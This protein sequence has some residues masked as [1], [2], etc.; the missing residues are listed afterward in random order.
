MH[1]FDWGDGQSVH[2]DEWHVGGIIDGL[3]YPTGLSDLFNA[4]SGWNPAVANGLGSPPID[5][6][7]VHNPDGFAYGSL[8]LYLVKIFT[9]LLAWFSQLSLLGHSVPGFA[10]WRAPD[11]ILAGRVLSGVFDTITVFLVF[12][13]AKR[14]ADEPAGL[15]AAALA[16]F[17]V[18][19]QQ[20]AHFTTVDS[21]L[22]TFTTGTILASVTLY[23]QGRTRD[24]AVLGLWLAAA[25]ATKASAVTLLALVVLAFL[26]RQIEVRR[27]I[28]W[29]TLGRA[30]LLGG[31][32]L[33]AFFLFQPYTFVDW[34]SFKSGLQNQDYLAIG[35]SVV[36]YTIK[37]HGKD[38][39]LYPL[40]QLT[41]YSLGIPLALL[42][43]AGLLLQGI[44]A[45]AGRWT[46]GPLRSWRPWAFIALVVL[47]IVA[48]VTGILFPDHVTQVNLALP[49]LAVAAALL[50][51]NRRPAALVAFFVFVYFVCTG[52]LYMKY[53]R[54]MEPIVPALCVLA[55]LFVFAV[56]GKHTGFLARF[57]RGL[58]FAIGGSVLVLTIVYGLAY[59]H[60]Y[61]R[62]LTDL[63]AS[64]WLYTNVA[65]GTRIAETPFDG[66]IPL[67]IGSLSPALYPIAGVDT[68][69]A[70]DNNN[71]LSD[72]YDDD[73]PAKVH[74]IAGILSHA[75]YY[76]EDTERAISSFADYGSKYPY[77]RRLYKLL[78]GSGIRIQDPLGY[79]LIQQFVEHPQ[80]GPWTD[81]EEGADQNF[82]EYD[83]PPV[84]IFKN[85]GNLRGCLVKLKQQAV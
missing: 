47:I 4:D 74:T 78:L 64:R 79:T 6:H 62:P 48:V 20:L 2:P 27:L 65:P 3:K 34:Q 25:L 15:F 42:A 35:T 11:S 77:T 26:W 56:A 5:G 75:Q 84:L 14:L 83:H 39:L 40:S 61:S 57:R 81:T 12:L 46:A 76:I 45:L 19:S 31:V 22:G 24:Y 53:L 55:A 37:W 36:F 17:A 9:S 16:C 18:L 73:S 43:Y 67:G 49:A 80:L 23:Q 29:E 21:F 1:S 38:A 44:G 41:N 71:R 66:L 69:T 33:V 32:A 63:Q 28:S 50:V 59:Q 85:T 13:I 58:G 60:I 51:P 72:I 10:M 68:L 70:P 82:N 7:P 54:Y 52:L 30:L 8:P